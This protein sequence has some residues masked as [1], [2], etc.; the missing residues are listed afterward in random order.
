MAPNRQAPHLI[1]AEDIV[2]QRPHAHLVQC[3]FKPRQV[4]DG[5]V[6]DLYDELGGRTALAA[7]PEEPQDHLVGGHL[8][9][10][11]QGTLT[12]EG[13]QMT[14]WT[15]KDIWTKSRY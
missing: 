7:G 9:T 12:K 5:V 15:C 10:L 2:H 3:P 14:I 13:S 6:V 1:R 11:R 8:V 4:D